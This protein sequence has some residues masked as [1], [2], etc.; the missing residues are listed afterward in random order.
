MKTNLSADVLKDE[1]AV[2]LA[3]ALAA[4]NERARKSGIDVAK[5]HVLIAQ[6][7]KKGRK[8][9]EISYGP[10]DFVNQRGGDYIIVVDAARGKVVRTLYGQ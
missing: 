3:R 10:E 5:S 7:A 4:A 6:V 9:W 2:S 1:L 8:L